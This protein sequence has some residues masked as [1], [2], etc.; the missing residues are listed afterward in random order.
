[1]FKGWRE[2]GSI[3]PIIFHLIKYSAGQI[4]EDRGG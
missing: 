4:A 1:M 2:S 3:L